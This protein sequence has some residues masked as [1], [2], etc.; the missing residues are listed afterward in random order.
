MKKQYQK[1]QETAGVREKVSEIGV[2]SEIS[3]CFFGYLL[4]ICGVLKHYH[5]K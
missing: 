2:R 3:F 5:D 4:Y 1:N